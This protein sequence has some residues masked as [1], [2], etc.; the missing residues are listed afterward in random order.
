MKRALPN[1]FPKRR[2]RNTTLTTRYG[3]LGDHCGAARSTNAD[4][5]GCQS[6]FINGA[7]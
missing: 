7:S 1:G 6:A 3:S 2:S 4:K 5:S